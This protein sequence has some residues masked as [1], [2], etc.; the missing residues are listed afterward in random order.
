MQVRFKV[1]IASDRWAYDSGK[2]YELPDERALQWIK[3][4]HAEALREGPGEEMAV[5]G[6]APETGAFRTRKPGK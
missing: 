5:A 4:G 3:T 1:S 2:V 6:G